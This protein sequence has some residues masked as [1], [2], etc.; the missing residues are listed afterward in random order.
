MSEGQ[1][2][3]NE[4]IKG[5]V[6]DY[7][8]NPSAL[9]ADL[10]QDIN[11]WDVSRVT[12]M[13]FL[14]AETTFDAP[15]DRWV[16]SG[17]TNM[18][19][20]F[21]NCT[22]FNQSLNGWNVSEV[23]DMNEMFFGCVKFNEPLNEWNIRNVRSTVSMFEGCSSFDQNLHHWLP[24]KNVNTRNMFEGCPIREENLPVYL[25]STL[26]GYRDDE[27]N[28]EFKALGYDI[29]IDKIMEWKSNEYQNISICDAIKLYTA[30]QQYKFINGLLRS[31][32]G[33]IKA[34]SPLKRFLMDKIIETLD[35]YFLYTAPRITREMIESGENITY[36]GEEQISKDENGDKKEGLMHSYISTSTDP[37]IALTNYAGR[38]C[39]YK[40]ILPEGMPYIKVNEIVS[41]EDGRHCA[42]YRNEN[43]VLLP[44]GLQLHSQKF[45]G[46]SKEGTMTFE[47]QVEPP[48]YI[49]RKIELEEDEE[50]EQSA[51]SM[52]KKGGIK[53]R[54]KRRVTNRRVT[55]RRGKKRRVTKRKRSSHR[56]KWSV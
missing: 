20:M 54:T 21:K 17:V 11:D 28:V 6:S 5:F 37:S 31:H 13:S 43:E 33:Y 45:I 52:R 32:P 34:M 39:F 12:D 38:C 30:T 18:N 9:P 47:L 24:S 44:R 35:N 46:L 8:N 15:L 42:L 27:E 23:R 29:A 3:D 14:F 50:D 49:K 41:E 25:L 48:S 22:L 51:K 10:P 7:L 4:N 26:Y 55:N 1:I 36:R 19:S 53:R 2:I 16:V 56:I 40:Y